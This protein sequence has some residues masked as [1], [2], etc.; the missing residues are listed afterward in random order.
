MGA[1]ELHHCN[2]QRVPSLVSVMS[3]SRLSAG[4]TCLVPSLQITHGNCKWNIQAQHAWWRGVFMYPSVMGTT[5]WSSVMVFTIELHR[6]PGGL[7]PASLPIWGLQHPA[8]VNHVCLLE[9]PTVA[10]TALQYTPFATTIITT[11][12]FEHQILRRQAPAP[13][14]TCTL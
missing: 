7:L 3:N 5:A 4:A 13:F 11:I 2:C 12:T 6:D 8:I 9:E 10:P 1:V 14:E